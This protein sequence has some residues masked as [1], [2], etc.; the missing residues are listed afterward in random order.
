[1]HHL[2]CN[3]YSNCLIHLVCKEII[4]QLANTRLSKAAREFIQLK[5][6]SLFNNNFARGIKKKKIGKTTFLHKKY[7]FNTLLLFFAPSLI[8][9]SYIYKER[10][11]TRRR[12]T[13]IMIYL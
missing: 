11:R 1:M 9:A 2:L 13:K 12:G 6:P 3:I 7:I 8:T 10:K 4:K 5:D